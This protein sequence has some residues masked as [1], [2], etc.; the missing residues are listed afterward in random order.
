MCLED[1]RLG[2]KS[3]SMARAVTVGNG[4][5]SRFL[6]PNENRVALVFHTRSGLVKIGPEGVESTTNACYY[7]RD[8]L[9][10]VVVK[11]EDVGRVITGPWFASGDGGTM[12]FMCI[13]R[14][15]PQV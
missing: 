11:I 13:E 2:R 15:N 4:A 6:E 12:T 5:N 1:I 14:S 9:P 7:V 10:P 8:T 3:D